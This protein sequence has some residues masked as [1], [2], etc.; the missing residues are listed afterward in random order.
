MIRLFADQ[1]ALRHVPP[2]P[3]DG[4]IDRGTLAD[5]T[6]RE[7]AAAR[8]AL[9]DLAQDVVL[10]VDGDS[11]DFAAATR[12]TMRDGTQVDVDARVR[13]TVADGRIV[14]MESRLDAEAMEQW[15]AVLDAGGFF[16]DSAGTG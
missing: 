8:R 14:G 1:V 7:I 15:H 4:P 11:L 13:F 2:H 16:L 12:G 10:K 9:T 6:T 3:S 5:I